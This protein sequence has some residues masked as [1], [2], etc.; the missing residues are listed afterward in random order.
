MDQDTLFG[1]DNRNK[2]DSIC[3]E[4]VTTLAF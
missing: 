4:I 2:Q 3:L 1:L